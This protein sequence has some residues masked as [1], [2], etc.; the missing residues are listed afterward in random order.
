[1]AKKTSSSDVSPLIL[2]IESHPDIVYITTQLLTS[3]GYEVDHVPDAQQAQAYLQKVL[4]SGQAP[5]AL[6]LLG[7][8]EDQ[9]HVVEFLE[10]LAG[11]SDML[12][13]VILFSQLPRLILE[14]MAQK[15][16]AVGIVV[17]PFDLD[18]LTRIVRATI[19]PGSRTDQTRVLKNRSTSD[20]LA[21]IRHDTSEPGNH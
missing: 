14:E 19:G 20:E 9:S 11:K 10:L 13:R 12:P 3:E 15:I 18:D 16:R 21:S 2:L 5:P 7:D 1:M 6:T 8:L 4:D 17:R